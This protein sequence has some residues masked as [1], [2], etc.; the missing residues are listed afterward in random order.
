MIGR[1]AANRVLAAEGLREN[2]I[3]AVGLTG[4]LVFRF[5][6]LPAAP[7]SVP[8][9]GALPVADPLPCPMPGALI[10]DVA[11]RRAMPAR[12]GIHRVGRP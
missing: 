8:A 2:P 5:P 4:P 6:G 11:R 3:P 1:I 10:D 9:T 7:R 12:G